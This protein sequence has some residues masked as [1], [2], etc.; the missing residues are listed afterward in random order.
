MPRRNPDARSA[1]PS[2]VVDGCARAAGAGVAVPGQ[3]QGFPPAPAGL[4]AGSTAEQATA[5][6][7]LLADLKVALPTVSDP[8]S[9]VATRTGAPRAYPVTVL[10]RADG[11][12][13]SV[14]ARPFDS[15]GQFADVVRTDLGIDS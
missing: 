15:A 5:G 9:V 13:A 12:V 7:D 6:L 3:S 4:S 11:S 8:Q 14:H 2:S 10:L 1:A